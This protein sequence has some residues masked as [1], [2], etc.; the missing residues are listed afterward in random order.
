LYDMGLNIRVDVYTGSLR[1][2]LKSYENNGDTQLLIMRPGIAQRSMSFLH[3]VDA[4]GTMVR[5]PTTSSVLL[6]HP[7]K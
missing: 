2:T 4:I 6:L 5:G 1:K 7:G 3:W